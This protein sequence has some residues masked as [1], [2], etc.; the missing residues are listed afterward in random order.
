MNR[1]RMGW[2]AAVVIH[3]Q[4][5]SGD[6]TLLRVTD[7]RSGGWRWLVLAHVFLAEYGRYP[8]KIIRR[9]SALG[10]KGCGYWGKAGSKNANREIS[11]ELMSGNPHGHWGIMGRGENQPKNFP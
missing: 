3:A 2:L 7:P 6:G 11:E 8:E 4:I 10:W 5:Q 1:S 9:G